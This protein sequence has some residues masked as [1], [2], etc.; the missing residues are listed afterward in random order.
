MSA[1]LKMPP[2]VRAENFL[3]GRPDL[4]DTIKRLQVYQEAGADV[5]YGATRRSQIR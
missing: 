5:F 4:D 2:T 1:G 3:V